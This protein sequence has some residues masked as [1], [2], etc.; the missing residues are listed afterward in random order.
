MLNATHIDRDSLFKNLGFSLYDQNCDDSHTQGTTTASGPA[1]DE[2]GIPILQREQT[3]VVKQCDLMASLVQ[4][5]P[6]EL[7]PTVT[8]ASTPAMSAV[9]QNTVSGTLN[10]HDG[11]F[12]NYEPFHHLSVT[13][14]MEA[15][16]AVYCTVVNSMMISISRDKTLKDVLAQVV[17]WNS[18]K[19][20]RDNRTNFRWLTI[21]SV[22]RA[23]QNSCFTPAWT[24]S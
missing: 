21:S 3:K 24:A 14:N 17:S 4:L 13:E 7:T 8:T 19:I 1:A 18:R 5:N 20:F 23:G 2:N 22:C 16:M 10:T 9:S 6:P 15:R 12:K 11:R